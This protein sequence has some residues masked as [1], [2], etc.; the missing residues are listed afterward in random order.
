MT[1]KLG[2]NL[3]RKHLKVEPDRWYYWADRLGVLV[4]QDMPAA[5]ELMKKADRD[6]RSGRRVRTGV[7]PHDRRPFQSSLDCHVGVIQ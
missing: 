5:E 7:A 2:F 3:S 4:W 1:R 6:F